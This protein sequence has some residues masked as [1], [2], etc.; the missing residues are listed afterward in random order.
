MSERDL[1]VRDA[2][3]Q[4]VVPEQSPTF[5]EDLWD[6][7]HRREHSAVVRWRRISIALAAVAIAAIVA[8]TVLAAPHAT[9]TTDQTVTCE[10]QDQGGLPEISVLVR[11]ESPPS[12]APYHYVNPAQ[13]DI[14]TGTAPMGAGFGV[15]NNQRLFLVAGGTKGYLLSHTACKAGGRRPPLARAGLPPTQ[16]LRRG[17]LGL[18]I[19]CLG[20]AKVTLRVR[21]T[22]N[23]NGE[24]AHVLLAVRAARTG[25]ALVFADWTATLVRAAAAP[26]CDVESA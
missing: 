2:L 1:I 15:A 18:I 6:L 8:A 9:R 16:T 22:Q 26:S 21:L 3:E 7:V 12:G 23:A 13:L 11:P 17:F 25:K 4:H 20:P 10:L 14:T 5:F 24:P 19:R